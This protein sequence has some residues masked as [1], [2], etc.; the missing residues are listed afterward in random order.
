MRQY[1]V[2]NPLDQPEGHEGVQVNFFDD[3]QLR[4]T[5]MVSRTPH[6]YLAV[7]FVGEKYFSDSIEEGELFLSAPKLR[8]GWDTALDQK[9]A[10]EKMKEVFADRKIK[11]FSW[12][13]MQD[14]EP[15]TYS[16]NE[17]DVFKHER[18]EVAIQFKPRDTVSWADRPYDPGKRIA[19][20]TMDS[21][22]MAK[23]MVTRLIEETA[24]PEHRDAILASLTPFKVFYQ[25]YVEIDF[26]STTSTD[27]A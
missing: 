20:D 8:I 15:V 5:E 1:E 12:Q 6:S 24:T 16:K 4:S 11:E 25:R 23:D 7:S 14:D 10:F 27:V 19:F 9:T 17:A 18:E 2:R 3:D 13:W 26:K 22:D 21:F